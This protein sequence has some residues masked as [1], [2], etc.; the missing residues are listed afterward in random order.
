MHV[1]LYRQAEKGL[2]ARRTLNHSVRSSHD[3]WSQQQL[4]LQKQVKGKSSKK[5]KAGPGEAAVG[6]TEDQENVDNNSMAAAPE[7]EQEA[8]SATK[9]ISQ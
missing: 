3:R 8:L 6:R 4:L 7:E 9:G 1:N 2:N 5:G